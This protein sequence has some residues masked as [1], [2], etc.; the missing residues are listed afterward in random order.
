MQFVVL[1]TVRERL[2][3]WRSGPG[4]PGLHLGNCVGLCRVVLGV[5]LCR[6]EATRAVRGSPDQCCKHLK[7][8]LNSYIQGP[9]DGTR[10]RILI[11]EALLRL[12][13]SSYSRSTCSTAENLV[14]ACLQDVYSTGLPT[15]HLPDRRSPEFPIAY[16]VV[17]ET[18]G[19]QFGDPGAPGCAERVRPCVCRNCA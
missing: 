13:I 7:K 8:L 6:A 4:A 2:P 14:L 5:L 10:L 17:L 19:R 18:Y 15:P 16:P 12:S 1:L 3:Y 11:I 9:A